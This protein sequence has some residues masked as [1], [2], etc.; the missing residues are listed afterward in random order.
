M[1]DALTDA[2]NAP[3]GRLAEVLIKKITRGEN[4]EEISSA[5]RE[6]LDKLASAPGSFGEL[7][8]VRLAAEVSYLFE[9]APNWTQERI[10]PL[11]NWSSSEAL[12]FWS[13]RKYSNYIGSPQ[14]FDLTKEWFLALFGRSEIGE[15]DLRV[16]SDWL[17]LMMI[18]N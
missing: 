3:P 13:A 6:R 1:R 18:A 15:D 5:I 10:V 8:R 11:F 14:L 7:A 16:Y 2:L 4:G 9:R 17:I 12:H